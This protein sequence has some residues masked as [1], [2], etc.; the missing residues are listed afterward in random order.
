VFAL[1]RYVHASDPH[2]DLLLD[3]GSQSDE[4]T[5]L[6]M[7]VAVAHAPDVPGHLFRRKQGE[8]VRLAGEP[9]GRMRETA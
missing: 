4:G 8:M 1:M 3:R 7:I 5:F 9:G 2:T 6:G